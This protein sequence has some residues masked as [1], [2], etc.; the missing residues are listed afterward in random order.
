MRLL[1][2]MTFFTLSCFADTL[3]PLQLMQRDHLTVMPIVL[4][5]NGERIA[6]YVPLPERVREPMAVFGAVLLPGEEILKAEI[7][8]EKVETAKPRP[9]AVEAASNSPTPEQLALMREYGLTVPPII[10]GRET[11]TVAVTHEVKTNQAE[12]SC[13]RCQRQH[14]PYN[15]SPLEAHPPRS[16]YHLLN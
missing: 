13:P 6:E 3:T 16:K 4:G 10:Q 7:A 1:V 5:V 15:P 2:L 12:E 9:I 8:F 11:H 14:Y